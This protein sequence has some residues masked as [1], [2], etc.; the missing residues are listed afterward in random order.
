MN[1]R[2]F[3]LLVLAC[4]FAVSN[5]QSDN[6]TVLPWDA[7]GLATEWEAF[8]AQFQKNYTSIVAEIKAFQNWLKN[9]QSAQS[10]NNDVTKTWTEGETQFSDLT[11]TEF[12]GS[13]L[14][15]KVPQN[16][17][18]AVQGSTDA[19]NLAAAPA[20]VDWVGSGKVT[21]VKNQASCGSCWAFATVG[22]LESLN[23]IENRSQELYSEQQLV[24]CTNG[25]NVG[26][27]A[28]GGGW[29]SGAI[30]WI[31]TNGIA[32]SSSYPYKAAYTGQSSCPKLA[33][34]SLKVYGAGTIAQG[35]TDELSR[36]VAI[37]PVIVC[38][39]AT[40][41]SRYTGGIFNNCG[42]TPNHAVLLVGYTAQYW[43]IKNS[44]GASWGE[45]GYIRL[46][47]G[48]T[49]G[50]ANYAT[51]PLRTAN[52]VDY[53]PS[54]GSWVSYCKTNQYVIDNCKLTCKGK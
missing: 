9:S 23:L 2:I 33:K 34:S 28:C 12:Q 8:K 24:D 14:T 3:S 42:T 20:S 43:V 46:A 52:Y 10:T 49:C 18:H 35:N 41:W 27:S 4:I 26:C 50:I 44:W 21:P 6:S 16:A 53:N 22:S 17:V 36:A 39:D 1:N 48:N 31:A 7:K 11:D 13:Y 51:Y 37:Q 19:S 47:K 54:C 40:N 15:L 38:V 32:F 5:A 45:N 30:G 25:Q 29:P